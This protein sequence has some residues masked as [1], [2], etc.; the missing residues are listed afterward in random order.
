MGITLVA[1]NVNGYFLMALA[2]IAVWLIV[3]LKMCYYKSKANS[4]TGI[5]LLLR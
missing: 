4:Q 2:I 1:I 5:Y 3:S